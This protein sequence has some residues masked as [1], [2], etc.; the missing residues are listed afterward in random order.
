MLAIRRALD[1]I[2]GALLWLGGAAI[3]LMMVH[4]MLEVT[5]RTAFKLTIPGTEETVS[6]YYMIACAFLPLAWVQRGRAHVSVEVFT[7]WMPARALAALD[8]LV[9]LACAAGTAI[10]AWAATGKA[11]AMTRSGEIL[12]GTMDVVVWPSRWFVPVGLATMALYMLLHAVADLHW[13][14]RGGER[15]LGPSQGH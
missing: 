1:A 11:I 9:C 7:L 3:V 2:S 15:L 12:I 14:A 10:F 5:L 8:G 13:A 4:I 6:A